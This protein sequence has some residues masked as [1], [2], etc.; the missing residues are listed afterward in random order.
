MSSSLQE[1]WDASASQPFE[2]TIAKS[3]QF[4]VGFAL[5]FAAL[6]L[7]GLFGLNN[8]LKNLSLYALPASLTFG[9]GAVYMICAVGV[10]VTPSDPAD[11]LPNMA[12]D[13][14]LF[15]AVSSS[16]RQLL[17]LL[18]CISFTNK[19]HVRIAQEGLRITTEDSTVMEAFIFLERSLFTNYTYNQPLPEYSQ[20]DPSDPPHF[21]VSL[22]SL[23]ETL[24]I[25]TL[26]DPN[27][28]KRPDAPDA[29]AAH[30]LGR[31]AGIDA[32]TSH[33][34]G[35]CT[36]SY[37]G[38]GYPL[39][40]HMSETGVTTT[41]DLT[42]YS[43]VSNE[44]IPFARD[45][46]ALKT[47]MRS[48]SLLD[49][50]AELSNMSPTTITITASPSSDSHPTLSFSAAGP[51]GSSTVELTTSTPSETPILETYTCHRKTAASYT[52]SL[53]KAAQRAMATATKV[54]LRID[55]EGVLNLQ[56]LVDVDAVGGSAGHTFVEFRVVP[57]RRRG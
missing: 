30:R 1:I 4:T 37:D 29:F 36:F 23:L 33:T 3:Q 11:I 38:E 14:T 46:I 57:P 41:C 40:I 52:F 35:I 39:S 10:Y 12:I 25:F 20:D 51:L 17:Q 15:T 21:Q 18:R 56:F 5:L 54:S 2:P 44:E 6:V 22:D 9:F 16:A 43:P 50:V 42:T 49:A 48:A 47:I 28:T 32:F 8:N 34:A 31:H 55:E 27:A 24:N 7:T 53:L 26:S 13:S 19:A 45:A